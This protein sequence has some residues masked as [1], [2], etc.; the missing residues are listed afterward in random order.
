MKFS[1]KQR[2]TKFSHPLV[3]MAVDIARGTTAN[4]SRE[5]VERKFREQLVKMNGGNEG[6]NYHAFQKHKHDLF[7]IVAESLDIIVGEYL[8]AQFSEFV[9]IRNVKLGDKIL[10]KIKKP[11]LFKV[12]AIVDGNNDIRFQNIDKGSFTVDTKYYAVGI[13]EQID[14]IL[15]GAVSWTEMVEEVIPSFELKIVTDVYK[16]IYNSYNSLS[17]TYAV[18]GS[19]DENKLRTLIAH[20]EAATQSRAIIMGTKFA[21]G[22]VTTAQVSDAMKD[23]YFELGHYGSFF[24]TQMRE[25]KQVH[26]AGTDTFAIDDNFLMV[27]PQG[28]E[29]I[30]KMIIE[31]DS[32]IIEE[33]NTNDESVEYMFKKKCGIAVVAAAKYGI[34]RLA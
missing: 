18:S 12:A 6:V 5:E 29:K 34:Y 4:F 1:L 7:A 30:V 3:K 33:E 27:V 22:K 24:G 19:F 10:F 17:S 9:E 32:R 13:M 8:D 16:A 31:G 14:R 21:L 2:H 25:V 23:K 15:T 28:N 11:H 20:V 26:E